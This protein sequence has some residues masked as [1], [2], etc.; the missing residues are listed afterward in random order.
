[1]IEPSQTTQL[2]FLGTGTPNPDPNRLGPSAAVI[3]NGQPYVIDCGAG[4]VRQTQAARKK[5]MTA[6]RVKNL[7]RLFFTHLHSDHT[8]GYPDVIFTP[9]VTGREEP[10]Q[11][12]GPTGTKH[13][14][15]HILKAFSQDVET[16]LHGGE[17]A[18]PIAYEV[19]VTEFGEGEVYKDDNVRVIAFEV[20]HG[21][22]Q[23]AYGLRF[24]TPDRVI[25]FSG[26]TTYCP[27]LIEHARGCDILV[28]EAYS[29]SGLSDRA[30]EWKAY[31]STFHTSGPDVGRIAAEINPKVVLLYH[32]LPFREP[33]EQVLQE[34]RTVY[35]GDVRLANDLDIF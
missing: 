12:W 26:D 33:E 21:T 13:M 25:V 10:L 3:V 7:T 34:V 22:W 24:E 19:K 16:R 27:N 1:M 23:N 28:H 30:P 14:T 11:V 35:D 9:A 17:P 6:L 8:I 32:L 20:M 2:V 15:D 5:G 31:H 18:I 29:A 4:V